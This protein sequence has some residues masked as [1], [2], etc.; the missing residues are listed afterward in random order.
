VVTVHE[1]DASVL[2]GLAVIGVERQS[3]ELIVAGI[4][5]NTIRPVALMTIGSV[6]AADPS[7][8]QVQWLRRST[9]LGSF[10]ST[11]MLRPSGES[12]WSALPSFDGLF[13]LDP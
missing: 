3:E 1:V 2:P 12:P 13:Q 4:P 11:A 8:C 9:I 7:M 5:Q 10:M 6:S